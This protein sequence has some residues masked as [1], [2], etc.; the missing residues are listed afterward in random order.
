MLM[1]RAASAFSASKEK[2]V[3]SPSLMP[4]EVVCVSAR[5]APTAP[6]ALVA[7]AAFLQP[8]LLAT[9]TFA[10]GRRR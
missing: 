9:L 10:G 5:A 7:A 8:L 3:A 1:S 2:G 6:S 4:L